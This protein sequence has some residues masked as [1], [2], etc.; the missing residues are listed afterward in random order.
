MII[1]FYECYY[2]NTIGS[3]VSSRIHSIACTASVRTPASF[4]EPYLPFYWF[5]SKVI[6]KNLHEY[7]N[8]DLIFMLYN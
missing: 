2:Q 8:R 7:V 6:E 5:F 1:E 3:I 4:P